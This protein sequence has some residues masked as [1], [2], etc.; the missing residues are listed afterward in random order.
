MKV[1][2]I[3]H[4][5]AGYA[6]SLTIAQSSVWWGFVIGVVIGILK[7]LIYDKLLKKGTPD[8]WDA[9]W[10]AAGCATAVAVHFLWMLI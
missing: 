1:D 2:K 6:I 5:L 8:V 9:V 7:E 3:L 10:T 4:F